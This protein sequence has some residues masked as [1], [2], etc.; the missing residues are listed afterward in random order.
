MQLI[1]GDW[2]ITHASSGGVID[3]VGNRGSDAD[4]ADFTQPL[5]SHRV[6]DLIGLVDENYLDIVHIR[7]QRHVI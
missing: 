7:I 3:G 4:N 2:K 6:D 1:Q 5:D